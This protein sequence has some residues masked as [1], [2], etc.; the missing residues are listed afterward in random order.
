MDKTSLNFN[1]LL[2]SFTNKWVAVSDDYGKVF[3][4]G[5]TLASVVKKMK[6]SKGIKIFRVIPFD[7]VYS[8]RS[9]K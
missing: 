7:M 6:Y 3:A 2:K 8:P 4:S 9:I 1:K 5:N